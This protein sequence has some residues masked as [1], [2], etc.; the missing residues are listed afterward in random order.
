MGI[1]CLIGLLSTSFFKYLRA[2]F[3]IAFESPKSLANNDL[4]NN[5]YRKCGVC[6][7]GCEF[8]GIDGATRA[9]KYQPFYKYADGDKISFPLQLSYWGMAE[10]Y[11]REYNRVVLQ[12]PKKL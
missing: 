5:L 6:G 8:P 11:C 2:C 7:E 9:S 3:A 12:S 10:D 4:K 1:L